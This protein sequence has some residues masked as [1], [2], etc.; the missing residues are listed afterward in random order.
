[1]HHAMHEAGQS[2]HQGHYGRLVA[3]V[4]L[5]FV[6]MYILMYAMV[7][8]FGNVYNSVNQAYMAGLMAAPMLLI[9]LALM[10]FMYPSKRW[11]AGLAA[12]AVAI[13]V[14]CWIGIRQQAGVTDQQF[15]RSMIPHHAGAIL[16][17]QEAKLADPE[18]QALCGQII[19]AQE[20]EIAQM[21]ALLDK[22]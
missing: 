3:M 17:C 10:R 22:R 14:L 8:A 13:A 15:L 7:D 16:M 5:S 18:I 1:M 19:V 6:A 12:A 4:A 9:E 20:A 11:N 21:K 2:S